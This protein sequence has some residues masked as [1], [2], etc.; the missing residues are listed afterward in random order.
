MLVTFLPLAISYSIFIIINA[1][2]LMATCLMANCIENSI[3]SLAQI[4]DSEFAL[5]KWIFIKKLHS[6]VN[7][8][9]KGCVLSKQSGFL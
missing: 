8:A 3:L 7:S 2:K 4:K 9:K 1:I 5:G 6:T